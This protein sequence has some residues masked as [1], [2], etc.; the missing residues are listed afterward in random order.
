MKTSKK[1]KQFS[2]MSNMS[3]EK[4]DLLLNVKLATKWNDSSWKIICNSIL[5]YIKKQKL[6]KDLIWI[7]R[8]VDNTSTEKSFRDTFFMGRGIGAWAHIPCSKDY[9][10]SN[11]MKRQIM[12]SENVHCDDFRDCLSRSNFIILLFSL[13][14]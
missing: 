8:L 13:M 11:I 2:A 9:S 3:L 14:I 1:S 5:S 4:A 12:K 6:W 7:I 10:F